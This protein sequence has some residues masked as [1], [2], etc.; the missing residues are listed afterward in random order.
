MDTSGSGNGRTGFAAVAEGASV[1]CAVGHD[2]TVYRFGV[3]TKMSGMSS[4]KFY[5]G[6]ITHDFLLNFMDAIYLP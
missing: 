6:K 3:W 5:E 1:W 2:G 4:Q